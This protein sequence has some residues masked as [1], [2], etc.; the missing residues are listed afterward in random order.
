MPDLQ[1][2]PSSEPRQLLIRARPQ[3]HT[4]IQATLDEL[5]QALARSRAEWGQADTP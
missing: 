1:L 2:L 4:L 5:E 3:D